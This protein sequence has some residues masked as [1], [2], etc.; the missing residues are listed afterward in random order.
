MKSFENI[1]KKQLLLINSNLSVRVQHCFH[2]YLLIHI[3]FLA[4]NEQVSVVYQSFGTRYLQLG[5]DQFIVGAI[6]IFHWQASASYGKLI[7]SSE[8]LDISK[9]AWKTLS[10]F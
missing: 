5:H 7:L 9:E 3:P 6:Y 1:V 8:I 10:K 2:K 4:G